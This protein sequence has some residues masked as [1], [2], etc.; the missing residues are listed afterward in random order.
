[1]FGQC[2]NPMARSMRPYMVPSPYPG[3]Y[4]DANAERPLCLSNGELAP[5]RRDVGM[6]NWGKHTAI[7]SVTHCE[8]M[9]NFAGIASKSMRPLETVM[10]E[11][12]P[13]SVPFG[14]T[15]VGYMPSVATLSL[16]PYVDTRSTGISDR[17]YR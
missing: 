16:A 17:Y 9:D 12:G 2:Q 1:M 6:P 4:T 11:N 3:Y 7:P 15:T 5:R 10:T 8:A 13:I 14:P